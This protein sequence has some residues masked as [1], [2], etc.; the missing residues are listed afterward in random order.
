MSAAS[1]VTL[2]S[3]RSY[4]YL[5]VAFVAFVF[6]VHIYYKWLKVSESVWRDLYQYKIRYLS[7]KKIIKWWINR[8]KNKG[9]KQ[10]KTKK[11]KRRERGWCY[12]IERM[13]YFIVWV[14]FI[15]FYVSLCPSTPTITN[16]RAEKWRKKIEL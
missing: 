6:V 13:L 10:N 11:E 8:K 7:P 15:R 5:F 4:I 16:Q 1:I 3:N 12:C 2:L 14:K 9:T